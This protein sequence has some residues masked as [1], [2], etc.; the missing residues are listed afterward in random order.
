MQEMMKRQKIIN[1]INQFIASQEFTDAHISFILHREKDFYDEYKALFY[2]ENDPD[3]IYTV[4]V[5]DDEYALY[6][7]YDWDFGIDEH[8]LDELADGYSIYYMSMDDHAAV[9]KI[10]DELRD[11]LNSQEGLQIYLNY[12]QRYGVSP[13]LI[14]AINEKKLDITDLYTESNISYKIIASVDIASYSVVL[15]NNKNASNQYVTWFTTPTRKNGYDMGHYF[16]S[17]EDAYKDF[18]KR[19]KDLFSN[20]LEAKKQRIKPNKEKHYE[21]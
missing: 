10:I 19:A 1:E 11:D 6:H 13:E 17:F 16:D 12:C 7:I 9:W 8:F 3:E 21:R 2:L 14:S 18:E 20:Y 5:K 4:I 15:G